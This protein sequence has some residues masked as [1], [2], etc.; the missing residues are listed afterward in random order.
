MACRISFFEILCVGAHTPTCIA[1]RNCRSNFS[2]LGPRTRIEK[3]LL[4]VHF[5]SVNY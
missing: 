3:C 5:I 2:M 1:C 4:Q